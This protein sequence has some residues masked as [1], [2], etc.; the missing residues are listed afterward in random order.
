MP[1]FLQSSLLGHCHMK[2]QRSTYHPQSTS[3][4]QL[5]LP[6]V[7]PQNWEYGCPSGAHNKL[8]E[9]LCHQSFFL[10]SSA[11]AYLWGFLYTTRKKCSVACNIIF[12]EIVWEHQDY[13]MKL[14]MLPTRRPNPSHFLQLTYHTC[15]DYL[16][17]E[18]SL[19]LLLKQSRRQYLNLSMSSQIQGF[20]F[21]ERFS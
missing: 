2:S 14:Q 5:V 9:G 12:Q 11:K 6:E 17:T 8:A 1:D 19:S 18:V 4:I 3:F 15:Y 13:K 7:Q 20:Y 16:Q 10:L 21:S